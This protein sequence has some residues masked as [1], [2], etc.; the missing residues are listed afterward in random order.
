[1]GDPEGH[2]GDTTRGLR[3]GAFNRPPNRR[4]TSLVHPMAAHEA[5]SGS[6]ED[7]EFVAEEVASG[8]KPKRKRA[9]VPKRVCVFCGSSGTDDTGRAVS[10]LPEGVVQGLAAHYQ[11]LCPT[12]T[13][14]KVL[15]MQ[16][17]VTAAAKALEA[18]GSGVGD[19]RHQA[20][21]SQ[22]DCAGFKHMSKAS[23]YGRPC[24]C[25]KES[26][27]PSVAGPSDA[28]QFEGCM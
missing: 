8:A 9:P 15:G 23:N 20:P 26:A 17:T 1:M 21:S 13:P 2:A 18:G 19:G 28:I 4:R 16:A 24:S 3:S 11:R 25:S 5:V 10:G 14:A 22:S 7:E 27:S 6:E 12:C